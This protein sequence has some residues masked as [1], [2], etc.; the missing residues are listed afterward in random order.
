MLDPVGRSINP[1]PPELAMHRAFCVVLLTTLL[2]VPATA[3]ARPDV[4][5]F[6]SRGVT[7]DAL[8]T[9][10][11]PALAIVGA[12]DGMAPSVDAMARERSGPR[13]AV[14][15]GSRQGPR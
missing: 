12:R 6:D 14:G 13:T 10:R 8:R 11:V 3:Q 5:V 7:V 4:R 15:R 2:P 9:S 1:D